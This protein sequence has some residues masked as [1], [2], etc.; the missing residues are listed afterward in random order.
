MRGQRAG[1]AFSLP[2]FAQGRPKDTATCRWRAARACE[3]G[4]LTLPLLDSNVH[5]AAQRMLPPAGGGRPARTSR[6]GV[7]D[8]SERG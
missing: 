2:F 6:K 4:E 3:Q 5:R 1:E 7:L 8:K